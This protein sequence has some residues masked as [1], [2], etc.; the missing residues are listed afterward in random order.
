MKKILFFAA[1]LLSTAA[2]AD[3]YGVVVG[4]FTDSNNAVTLSKKF[5]GETVSLK[6]VN[7]KTRV[8][9]GNVPTHK[10]AEVLREMLKSEYPDAW[11]D[12]VPEESSTTKS[13]KNEED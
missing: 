10:D 7:G 12:T 3:N 11:I 9:V 2:Y 1:M 8:I 13:N 4:S 6:D 5:K